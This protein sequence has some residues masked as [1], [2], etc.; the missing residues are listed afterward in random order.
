[1]Y[2]TVWGWV[3][4]CTIVDTLMSHHKIFFN[5]ILCCWCWNYP[6]MCI[7]IFYEFE[8]SDK[9]T[10]RLGCS[11]HR[12]SQIVLVYYKWLLWFWW[13][14]LLLFCLNRKHNKYTVLYGN[15]NGFKILKCIASN[16][17]LMLRSKLRKYL[18]QQVLNDK[19]YYYPFHFS[20]LY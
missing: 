15:S 1:M 11:P 3:K 6:C 9:G 2:G 20:H 7:H 17:H 19:A 13:L 14:L 4:M 5:K 10:I 8:Y 12:F 16:K 18:P